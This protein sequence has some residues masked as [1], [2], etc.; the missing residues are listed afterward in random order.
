MKITLRKANAIQTAINDLL[1]SI[2][3][4]GTININEFQEP[5]STLTSAKEILITNLN[6]KL[7]LIGVLNNI[8]MEVGTA[9]AASGI[10]SDLTALATIDKQINLYTMFISPT[11]LQTDL[12]II[13]GQLN[14]IK[15]II[16]DSYYAKTEVTTGILSQE[17]I[18]I[19]NSFIKDLKKDK[20][21]IQDKILELNF[22]TE[23]VLDDFTVKILT[24]EGII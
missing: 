1:K 2:Q 10:D 24:A 5:E 22:K 18:D 12:S 8:R 11:N 4:S 21:A 9:N 6:R 3:L 15:T 7:D 17:D 23:I 20:Q 13:N 16:K 14:K 19:G